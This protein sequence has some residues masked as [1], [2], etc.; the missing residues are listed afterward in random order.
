MLPTFQNILSHPT[1]IQ[2]TV[3]CINYP[4]PLLFFSPATQ[5]FFFNCST[6]GRCISQFQKSSNVEI[7]LE[8]RWHINGVW[9]FLTAC[10]WGL[11]SPF[12]K[13]G[14]AAPVQRRFHSGLQSCCT[15]AHFYRETP[16]S[17]GEGKDQSRSGYAIKDGKKETC[18]PCL[19]AS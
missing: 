6:H 12:V 3:L 19:V 1:Y 13:K 9:S 5:F 18:D 4:Y 7:T 15:E 14:T 16:E 11:G 17:K 10:F 8:L 2:V